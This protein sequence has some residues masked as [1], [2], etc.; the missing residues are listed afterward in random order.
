MS[1]TLLLE[2]RYEERSIW[3]SRIGELSK[4]FADAGLIVLSAFISPFQSDRQLVRDLMADGEFVE[5]YMNTPLKVCEQR[6]P[7][8]L[9]QKAR[10]GEIKHFTGIDSEYEVPKQ[11]E[12][13][14][15]TAE[16]SVEE[17]ALMVIDYLQTHRIIQD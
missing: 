8:G 1:E 13:L 16:C 12:I 15:N 10:K 17:C 11:P 9:Y 7:K 6:D 4:L 5:I 3:L 14:L 2:Q